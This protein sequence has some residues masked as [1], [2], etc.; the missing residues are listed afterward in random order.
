VAHLLL[1][2][3]PP[4]RS[5]GNNGY[6]RRG[7]LTVV[8]ALVV[9]SQAAGGAVPLT[10]RLANALAVRGN[11]PASSAALAIDLQTGN[12][13][14]ERHADLS[15]APASNE[16]LPV[17]FAALHAL[18]IAYRFR[19]EVLS[20]GSLDGTT[21]RGNVYLKG[22]GDPTLTSLDLDRLATQIAELGVTRIAGRIVGDESWFDS[23]RTAPGWKASFFI[24]ECPPLSALVVDRDVY[25]RH[26]ALQPAVAAAG[27]FRQLL[28]RHGISSGPV[29][30][31]RAPAGA[32]GLA[33]VVSEPLPKILDEMDGDSD[34]FVAEML[35]KDLGAEV[36][37][38][39]TTA[40][41]VAVVV[42]DLQ[43][44]AIPLTGVRLA[45]GS[46]LSQLDRVT[47]RALGAILVTA[48]SDLDL[49]LPLWQALPV[50]G[51]TG[52]LEH[53]MLTPPALGNVRAKTGTTDRAS[54]LSGF[55]GDRYAFVVLQNGAPVSWF[56]ARKAQDR[57][58]TALA[59]A[60]GQ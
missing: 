9:C 8:V 47:A 38:G 4:R 28:R 39:G 17:T 30:T 18:G 58:A 34:N 2:R 7:L 49:Q 55:V 26:V 22:F 3:D 21:W 56:A 53:R 24:Q 32:L 44:A 33:Q 40:A 48:W 51:R 12:V 1:G 5:L 13:L 52:T 10:V 42:R 37:A 15:L 45:D 29:T 16:K 31:G 46:G 20:S 41:G 25:D 59:S 6:V 11:S 54:A 50:A 36:G 19:T 27:R 35:L 23:V 43:A 57:F 60:L 14:F